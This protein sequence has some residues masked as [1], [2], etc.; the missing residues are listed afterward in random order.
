M[1]NSTELYS[2]QG[3][4]AD[5]DLRWA[6]YELWDSANTNAAETVHVDKEASE[7]QFEA[8]FQSSLEGLLCE[9]GVR[10]DVADWYAAQGVRW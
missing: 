10:Q 4:I 9:R 5:G 6:V 7:D 1:P 8:V 3:Q 2:A